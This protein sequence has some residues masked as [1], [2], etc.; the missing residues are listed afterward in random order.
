MGK[1]IK[2]IAQDEHVWN[3]RPRPYPAAKGMPQWW[4][5]MP[6]YVNGEKEFDL[7]PKP[8]VT[9]KRCV[10]TIDM[11][12]AG[13]YV[14]L[15]ADVLIKELKDKDNKV[16]T[17][18]DNNTVP[19]A[20]WN[21]ETPVLDSWP[22]EQIDN[23][24]VFDGYSKYAFKNIH[25]W[26]IKTPPGWS[27]LFIHPVAYPDLP[28]KSISGIVDT[29][30]HDGEINVPFTIKNNFT[31]IIPSKTPMFQVIPFK[32]ENWESEFEMKKSNQHWFDN[33]KLSATAVRAYNLLTYSKKKYR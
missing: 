20:V 12:T 5:D 30:M 19:V 4:K 28:F 32:R 31:G 10:P 29:D 18:K 22:F 24:K 27:C 33:E 2:F 7:N 6:I 15:W 3:V 25:G 8:N 26:T 16:I 17:D 1:I 14:P 11:L 21:T 23:F 13:Y 9:V